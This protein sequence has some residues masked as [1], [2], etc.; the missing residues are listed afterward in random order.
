MMS[1]LSITVYG[2]VTCEDTAITTARLRA[3][4]IPFTL[5]N[6][7]ENSDVDALLDKY[8]QGRRVT[9]TLVFGDAQNVIAEP[10]LLELET[11]LRAAGYQFDA[12]R[13]DE[14]RGALKNQRLP[15]FTLPATRGDAVTLYKLQ[16][17]KRAVL[18]FV[19]EVNALV[20]QGYARQLTQPRELFEEYN[21]LPLPIARAD[22][23]TTKEWAHE[24][25]RAYAALSDADGSV[26][27]KYAALLGVNPT[28]TLLVILDSF[29]A[30]RAVSHAAD[31]GGLI[32]PAE[33]VSWLRLIDCECD[34]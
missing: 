14:I 9:P 33:I 7:Q 18:F 23:E 25:A 21:A 16:G 8:N 1:P 10:S 32:A 2:S 3:L 34:E 4:K 30:P 28:E 20:S 12:P 6:R 22:L 19:D 17:R 11:A 13:A 15:N 24:F 26:K 29:C 5:Y 31:A 27:R